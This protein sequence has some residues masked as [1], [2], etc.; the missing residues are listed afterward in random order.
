MFVKVNRGNFLER[1]WSFLHLF[2][3]IFKYHLLQIDQLW[4]CTKRRWAVL[5][6]IL[7]FFFKTRSFCL[8]LTVMYPEH[9]LWII[10][11]H[12]SITLCVWTVTLAT[13]SF[14]TLI[15]FWRLGRKSKVF[16]LMSIIISKWKL[17]SGAP[18]QFALTTRKLCTSSFLPVSPC[19]TRIDRVG[20]QVNHKACLVH[21]LYVSVSQFLY[22]MFSSHIR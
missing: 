21:F 9:C 3:F 14:Q 20:K 12:K 17:F 11:H 22:Y 18:H 1:K 16:R 10:N 19:H 4:I 6:L 15:Q 7:L 8:F 13:N 5:R 2:S